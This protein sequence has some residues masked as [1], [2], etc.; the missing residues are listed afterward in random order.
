MTGDVSVFIPLAGNDAGRVC[1]V[2]GRQ[3]TP[4]TQAGGFDP[5]IAQLA[6]VELQDAGQVAL[7][8]VR[9]LT[10]KGDT[11][12]RLTKPQIDRLELTCV[13]RLDAVGLTATNSSSAELGLA[14]ALIAQKNRS[15][16]GTFFA[17]GSLSGGEHGHS[18]AMGKVLA[19]DG[20]A[21][22]LSACAQWLETHKGHPW[23]TELPLFTPPLSSDGTTFAEAYG[24]ELTSLGA[25]AEA[26]GVRIVHYPVDSLAEAAAHIGAGK[27]RLERREIVARILAVTTAVLLASAAVLWSWTNAPAEFA[28]RNVIASD[29]N[30][31]MTPAAVLVDPV[32]GGLT[33][34]AICKDAMLRPRFSASEAM[35]I[36]LSTTAPIS[37]PASFHHALVVVAGETS[38]ARAFLPSSSGD[39]DKI[40]LTDDGH[41]ELVSTRFLAPPAEIMRVFAVSRKLRPFDQGAIQTRLNQIA[42]QVS[43]GQKRLDAIGAYISGLSNS[44]VVSSEINVVETQSACQSVP[45]TR[46]DWHVMVGGAPKPVPLIHFQDLNVPPEAPIEFTYTGDFGNLTM[47]LLRENQYLDYTPDIVLRDGDTV[48]LLE[49]DLSPGDAQF[50]E[51]VSDPLG[52]LRGTGTVLETNFSEFNMCVVPVTQ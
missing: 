9:V 10:S 36:R 35:T 2:V 51:V 31:P 17:T 20:I 25:R 52:Q 48:I 49:T 19:V 40:Q 21:Q 13:N 27:P 14:L 15:P 37:G 33:P 47:L 6:D 3:Q 11:R 29:P 5:A 39:G 34:R 46:C 30:S 28:F 4:E 43:A 1:H 12:F 26:V 16:C 50:A 23:G 18:P 45:G 42:L 8:A 32:S 22:K 24:Q 44:A 41:L 7:D 38:G